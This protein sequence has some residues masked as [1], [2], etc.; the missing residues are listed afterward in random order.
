MT[1][2]ENGK[3]YKIISL[4]TNKIYIGSTTEFYLSN[5]LSGHRTQYNNQEKY[6]YCTSFEILDHG[7]YDIILIE[8]WPCKSV[9]ELRQREEYWREQFKDV[10]VNKNSAFRNAQYWQKYYHDYHQKKYLDPEVKHQL[11]ENKRKWRNNNKEHNRLKSIE[12][13]KNRRNRKQKIVCSV[14]GS[15]VYDYKYGDHKQSKKHQKFVTLTNSIK[16][17]DEEFKILMTY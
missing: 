9:N 2:Y 8:N 4:H 1:K 6:Y 13:K 15:I 16:K 12:Y 11:L 7:D 3:I 17:T 5:R 10:C 14:C